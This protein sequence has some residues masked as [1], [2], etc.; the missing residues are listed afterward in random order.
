[1]TKYEDPAAG[2]SLAM[3]DIEGQA[4]LIKVRDYRTG[5]ST[6]FGEKDAIELDVVTLKT[7]EHHASILWFAGRVIGKLK[8]KVG[9][10]VLAKLERDHAGAKP[11]QAPPWDLIGLSTVP[12]VVEAADKWLASN[13][14]VMDNAYAD[15]TPAQHA[16][17]D[18]L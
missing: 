10:L 17:S 2:G 9:A 7:G 15:P 8:G 6:S 3:A 14:G 16:A 5:V 12:E 1:M 11:G 4:L 13:P 18:L